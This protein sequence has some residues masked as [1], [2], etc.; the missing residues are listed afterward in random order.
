MTINR[1]VNGGEVTLALGGRLDTNTSKDLE[2]EL[3]ECLDAASDLVFE[4]KDLE[5]TSSAG[6][7]VFLNCH[8][9]MAKKGGSMVLR[10]VNDTIMEV[11]ELT[12]FDSILT[13]E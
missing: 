9:K 11:F 7:R 12:G 10:D 2:K 4:L 6:L 5:Y 13:I 8:K 1:T 3:T